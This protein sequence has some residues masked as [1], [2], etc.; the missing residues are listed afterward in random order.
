MHRRNAVGSPTRANS[1]A[2]RVRASASPASNAAA[3][4]VVLLRQPILRPAGLPDRRFS[5]GRRRTR[6]GG[7]DA[8]LSVNGTSLVERAEGVHT[9]ALQ[10]V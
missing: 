1:T 7:L 10:G 8:S 3:A 2:L 5:D 9:R 4:N 6:P